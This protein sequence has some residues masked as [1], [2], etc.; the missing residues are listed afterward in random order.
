[1]VIQ[2]IIDVCPESNSFISS[3]IWWHLCVDLF[4]VA[5][6]NNREVLV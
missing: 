4:I 2:Q 1:M 6:I 5:Q 3:A